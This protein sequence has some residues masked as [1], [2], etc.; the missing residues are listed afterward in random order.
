MGV[1][2]GFGDGGVVLVR[3]GHEYDPD[4]DASA[5]RP[6]QHIVY[7]GYPETWVQGMEV[8]HNPHALR[9]LNPELLPRAVHN[10]LL[11][12]GQVRSEVPGWVPL[13]SITSIVVLPQADAT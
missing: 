3:R 11:S 2:A 6:Y 1:V 10:Y 5:P 4:P 13:S 12:D 8:Y 9:P 7:E